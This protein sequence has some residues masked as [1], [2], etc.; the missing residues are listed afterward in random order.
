[1]ATVVKMPKL[2]LEMEQGTVLEWFFGP[3]EAVAEGDTIA[4]VESEKSI[5]EVD[6][7]QDGVIRRVYVEE[8]DSVPPGTPI[9]ILAGED[10]DIA[11]AEA[12]AE[13]ELDAP[14][15]GGDAASA[16]PE[17]EPEPEPAPGAGA[18]DD[19][20]EAGEATSAGVASEIKASPRAKQRAEELGVDLTT[21]EGTGPMDSITEADVEAAA[22][23]D[24]AD[25]AGADAGAASVKASPR[26]KQRAEELGVDLT[27]VEGTGPMDSIT[28][29]DVEAAAESDGSDAGDAASARRSGSDAAGHYRRRTAVADPDAGGAL[30]GA[31][32]AV[33]SAFEERVTVTD[34]LV[35]VVSAALAE[36]PVANGTYAESTHQVLPTHDIALATEG[37]DGLHTGVIEAADAK[38]LSGIVEAREAL[39][40]DDDRRPTF[41]LADASDPDADGRLINPPGVAALT[42]DPTGRRAVPE[43][44]GTDLQPL[45]TADLTYD[46]R[47]LGDAD[48]EA[49]LEALFDAFGSASELVLESY[50]GVE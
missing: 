38:S 21:V 29:A 34:V 31:T 11:D 8:G 1:M 3:G 6:A 33:R 50:R 17:P 13:A 16:D 30:L 45:V 10:E 14:D 2:G 28:E 37:D 24:D 5:G 42:V 9:G 23:A 12:E 48:A 26:A 35:V 36:H 46:A 32:E 25:A 43:G 47:A 40:D 22:E 7:R 39:P 41:T 19:A 27:T 4:E 20:G 15:A 18:A 44:S 49:F